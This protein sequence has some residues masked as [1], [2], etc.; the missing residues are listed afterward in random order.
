M[1]N[2]LMNKIS[3]LYGESVN[4][5]SSV[6]SY[7]NNQVTQVYSLKLQSPP[8]NAPLT[9]SSQIAEIVRS[10]ERDKNA[11]RIHKMLLLS[12]NSAGKIT[13]KPCLIIL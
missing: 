4:Q 8:M 11:Q 13:Q 9:E 6:S 12:P 3:K 2:K 1:A 7:D 5:D 10:F